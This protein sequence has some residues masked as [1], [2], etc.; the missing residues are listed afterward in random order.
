[1]EVRKEG[2]L[3]HSELGY[4][5]IYVQLNSSAALEIDEIAIVEASGWVKE[6]K[7]WRN[8]IIG[9]IFN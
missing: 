6:E 1:M 3:N 7:S 2:I 4:E 8:K 9:D 5:Q